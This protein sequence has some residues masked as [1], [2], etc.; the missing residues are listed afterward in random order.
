MRKNQSFNAIC[1][2]ALMCASTV[3][4]ASPDAT[5]ERPAP[6]QGAAIQTIAALDVPRYMGIWYEIAKFPNRFQ[7]KCTSN[8]R[9]E[10]RLNPEGTVQVINRCKTAS[11]EVMEAVGEARQPGAPSSPKL[12]VRFAPA[13][14]SFLPM[15]WGEYWV[16]DLDDRYQIAAV[17]DSKREY[18]WILA[19]APQISAPD[20]QRLLARLAAQGFD[21]QKLEAT[22]Q[23]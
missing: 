8:T 22:A 11:G 6:A 9:A 15:V 19:R 14:L 17:S 10:Y 20:Y 16:I 21:I 2:A 4:A 7:R 3:S 23:D 13:W 12:E 1:L 5:P 18:L